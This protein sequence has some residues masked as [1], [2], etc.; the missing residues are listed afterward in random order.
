MNGYGPAVEDP[1]KQQ[2]LLVESTPR[3][4]SQ[5]HITVTAKLRLATLVAFLVQRVKKRERTVIFMSTCDGVDYHEALF[6]A[7]DSVLPAKNES[8]AA[9][10]GI[11]GDEC[12]IFK[13]HGNVPHSD[14]QNILSKFNNCKT[15]LLLATDVAARGLNL[16]KVDW[17]VQY[18]PHVKLQ[19]MLIVP[20]RCSCW[21]AGHALLFLLPSER[22]FLDVLELKGVKHMEALSVAH[23][24][25]KAAEICHDLTAESKAGFK[26]KGEAFSSEVQR[27]LEDTVAQDDLDTKANYKPPARKKG[28][29]RLAEP[30]GR[31]LELARQAFFS[32]VRAYP[33]KE[34]C[35]R[36]IFSSRSLHVGHIARS[37]ALKEPPKSSISKVTQT[38]NDKDKDED[39]GKRSAAMAFHNLLDE[40]QD[41]VE[42][43]RQRKAVPT[44]KSSLIK[45][46]GTVDTAKARIMLMERAAKLQQG[47]MSSF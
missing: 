26:N 4:L 31:L 23:T 5:L 28:V 13:L 36:H 20:P 43:K 12:P 45:S 16:S 6:K 7:M 40:V 11:F 21:S 22:Q 27:R 1:G 18:D 32:Y 33:T 30:C 44:N 47:G 10:G 14:R 39:G 8:E 3:Q 25:N 24:L 46:D 42:K 15:S 19:T 34:K 9:T 35:V 29:P 2:D 17:I 38:N 37:F 41:V